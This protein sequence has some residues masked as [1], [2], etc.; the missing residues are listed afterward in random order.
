MSRASLGL[1]DELSDYLRKMGGREDADLKALREATATHPRAQMQIAPEQGQL[2]ILLMELIGA[3][4]TIEVG[5]FTGYSAMCVAKAMGPEGRVVALD[6]SKEFTDLARAA[7]DKAGVTDRIDLRIAP[8]LD[9]LKA[10]VGAG[11]AGRFDFAFI[12]ADKENYDGYYEHC[13]MLLR[14]GGLI[15]IDNVLWSGRVIEAEDTSA[16]T[17]ALR[18]LNK[19]IAADERVTLSMVPIGDGLT[20]VRKR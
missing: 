7:W 9:S 19:K 11:E 10:M 5:T 4:R 1:D 6:I 8:A 2:L 20:L 12:D 16:A 3:K 18:A 15:G 17:E 13:L 14:P